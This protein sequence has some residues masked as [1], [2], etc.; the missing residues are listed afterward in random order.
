MGTVYVYRTSPKT[1]ES[2]VE[3]VLNTPDFQEFDPEEETFI[4]INANYD[5]DWQDATYQDGSRM[6]C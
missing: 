2:D 1:L 5:R 4:K 6:L 3:K